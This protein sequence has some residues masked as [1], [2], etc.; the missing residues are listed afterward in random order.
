MKARKSKLW[1]EIS[2]NDPELAEE[3]IRKSV[4]N[5]SKTFSFEYKGKT[6]ISREL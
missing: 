3:V 4:M 6:Y 2:L 5:G 1:K